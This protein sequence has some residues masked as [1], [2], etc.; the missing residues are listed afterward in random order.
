[1]PK[2]VCDMNI[3]MSSLPDDEAVRSDSSPLT[4]ISSFPSDVISDVFSQSNVPSDTGNHSVLTTKALGKH[5]A[6]K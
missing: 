4:P 5:R 2:P 6:K 1:M 3:P